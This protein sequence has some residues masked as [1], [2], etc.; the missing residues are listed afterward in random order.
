MNESIENVILTTRHKKPDFIGSW[1]INPL[2]ICDELINYFEINKSKQKRGVTTDGFNQ[3]NKN[4][5]DIT[6]HPNELKL[7]ENNIFESYFQ[8]LFECY[9]NYTDEWPFLMTFAEHL[10]IGSFK[11]QRYESGQHFQATHAERCSLETLHRVFAWMTYLNDVDVSAG[12]STYFS[13]Y[14][15][16]VQPKKGLTLIWPAEWTHAHKGNLIKTGSKYIITG[17]LHFPISPTSA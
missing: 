8:K 12:G 17:W 10:Q 2:S 13:H 9:Q 6:I 15:I 3:N 7:G 14:G 16:D 4:S 11:L 5:R 1:T